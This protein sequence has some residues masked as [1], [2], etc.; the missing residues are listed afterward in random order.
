MSV[1]RELVGLGLGGIEVYYRSWDQVT[2]EAVGAVARKLRLVA[3]GGSD[4]HGD[5]GPYAESHAALWV[6]PEVADHLRQA[7]PAR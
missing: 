7:L 1:L 5:L 6:P 4:Y 2:V 3:T